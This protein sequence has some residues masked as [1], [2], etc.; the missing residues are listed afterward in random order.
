M[1]NGH[2][3]ASMIQEIGIGLILSYVRPFNV[4]FNTRPLAS[5]HFCVLTFQNFAKLLMYDEVR[6]CL[7][8]KGTEI[9]EQGRIKYKG[10]IARNTYW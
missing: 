5:P 6:K 9:N 1:S 8:R 10:W 3:I 4:G 7:I 2:L